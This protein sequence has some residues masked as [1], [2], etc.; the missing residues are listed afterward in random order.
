MHDGHLDETGLALSTAPDELTVA[1]PEQVRLPPRVRG[2]LVV[3]GVLAA[4]AAAASMLPFV[5]V[6]AAGRALMGP[7]PDPGTAWAAVTVA[8]AAVVA[9]LLLFAAAITLSHV[10]ENDLA[11]A[12]RRALIERMSKVSLGWFT[13]GSGRVK[14]AV[15]DDVDALHH[16]VAHSGLELIAAVVAPLVGIGYLASVEWRLTLIAVTPL[17]VGFVLFRQVGTRFQR[18]F[19]ALAPQVSAINEATVEFVHGVEVV[20]TFGAGRR[21]Y[22]QFTRAADGYAD[23][24]ARF[25]R[26]LIAPRVR[27]ELV[28]SPVVSLLLTL[29]GAAWFVTE[30]WMTPADV[31][32]FAVLAAALSAPVLALSHAEQSLRAGLAARE[33]IGQ[34]LAAP[35]Q[36]VPAHPATPA[37]ATV[38][39]SGVTFGYDAGQPV[40]HGIDLRL[41]PGTI[42]A[43]VG[44]SG[45]GKSTLA[46]LVARIYDPDTG[47]VRIGGADARE[48]TRD[49]LASQI[50]VVFQ[51]PLLMRDTVR[52]NL[53]LAS[54]EA[55]P[56]AVE[57]AA[58]AA[59]ID[60]RIRQ[61]PHGYDTAIGGDVQ[62]S[63]GEQQRLAIARALLADPPILVL[64]EAVSFADP[65]SEAAVQT[66]LAHLCR[67][68][69]VLVV[70]HRLDTTIPADQIVVLEHGRI[71]EVGRHADLLAREGTYH[72]QWAAQHET[73]HEWG[74]E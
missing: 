70:A 71:A 26:D 55:T 10:A 35:I 42:T 9:R 20:K 31:L 66:A 72:R 22:H 13:R 68:R 30:G 1:E 7:R 4:G 34:V 51:D 54:P 6:A 25:T 50:G 17:V 61:L 40:L 33:R 39:L 27:A 49:T 5:A 43:V 28:L 12:I 24:F 18:G 29:A 52:A 14:Q 21:A 65:A 74:Q 69:T 8:G 45:A 73:Q 48:L 16:V 63:G 32:P 37:D 59:Q 41:A 36:V 64:D 47:T 23:A 11:R 58:T 62:L 57:R 46:A 38:T 15:T 53:Q 67:G 60:Q 56:S 44:P 3:A 19:S 2:Q